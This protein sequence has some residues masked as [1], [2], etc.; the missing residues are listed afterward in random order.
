MPEYAVSGNGGSVLLEFLGLLFAVSCLLPG[1]AASIGVLP[2][3]LVFRRSVQD[4]AALSQMRRILMMSYQIDVTPDTLGYVY[5]M[6]DFSLSEVNGRLIIQPGTQLIL[7]DIE[8]AW[9]EAENGIVY[10]YYERN[11]KLR[12][13]PL[14]RE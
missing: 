2:E 11:G 12:R 1:V 14:V 9:F 3:I 5:Q 7:A 13:A 10:V 4:E 8:T 6:R